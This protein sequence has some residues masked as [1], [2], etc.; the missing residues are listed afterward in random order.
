MLDL[1]DLMNTIQGTSQWKVEKNIQSGLSKKLDDIISS[2]SNNSSMFEAFYGNASEYPSLVRASISV[3][4]RA[5]SQVQSHFAAVMD[6]LTEMQD[7][8]RMCEREYRLYPEQ[9]VRELFE[10]LCKEMVEA[11]AFNI[12]TLQGSAA[13]RAIKGLVYAQQ[14]EIKVKDTSARIKGLSERVIKEVEY[15]HRRELKEAHQRLREVDRKQDEALR[16]LEEQ[17]RI[18]T[19]LQE[20]QRLL[21]VVADHQKVL[22]LL[23]Q[24]LARHK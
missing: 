23:Q 10:K 3:I 4:L 13:R 18:L 15:L 20:E 22:Q 11:A 24:L 7:A 8:L 1:S 6:A 17:Q 2:F 5:A 19:S 16:M 9:R 12:K 21:G 14:Q